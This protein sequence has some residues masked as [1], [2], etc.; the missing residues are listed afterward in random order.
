MVWEGAVEVQEQ[1][2]QVKI[3][4]AQHG[5]Q[6]QS[7][8]P[9]AG[10]GH[11]PKPTDACQV[12]KRVQI[13]RIS[14]QEVL[15]GALTT[16][17]RRKGFGSDG[18]LYGAVNPVTSVSGGLLYRAA[19]DGSGVTTIYQLSPTDDGFTPN[20]GLTLGSDGMLYGTT[21]FGRV[22]DTRTSG[23]VFRIS[24]TGTDFVVLHRFEAY[25]TTTEDS[26]PRNT[27]G[28]FPEAEL[29]DLYRHCAAVVYPSLMEGFGRPALEAMAVGR[30][31]I[32]SDIAVHRELFAEAAIFI[33]PGV[34]AS[35]AAAFAA[36]ED[37]AVVAARVAAGLRLAQRYTW[38]AAG[39][40][41]VA[42]LL[43]VE[44]GL[45]ALRR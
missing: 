31:A 9:I 3:I 29:I 37:R 33:T 26:T 4:P 45:E 38:E 42:A 11:Y 40:K 39:D 23:T 35:W 17:H 13:I 27:Q 2:D 21:K 30:P 7:S 44:P 15:L 20:A 6:R 22:G 14:G 32:L 10:I 16:W 25:T 12:H 34:P 1:A 18:A 41:L 43:A 36:L 28:A 19:P 5:R 8:H 24:Q